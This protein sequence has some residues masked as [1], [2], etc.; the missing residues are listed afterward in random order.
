[1]QE[2][3]ER[4]VFDVIASTTEEVILTSLAP[5]KPVQ[6]DDEGNPIDIP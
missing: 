1:M 2:I 3:Y 6:V 4:T 5:E